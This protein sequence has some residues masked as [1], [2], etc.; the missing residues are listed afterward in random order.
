MMLRTECASPNFLRLNGSRRSF[1]V[2]LEL[3]EADAF[4]TL[5]VQDFE[6]VAVE[7]YYD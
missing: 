3:R 2:L 6:G 1:R 4:G 7:N 5:A